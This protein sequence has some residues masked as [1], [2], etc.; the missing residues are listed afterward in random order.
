M[1][2]S[3][4]RGIN[5]SP[6]GNQ[7]NLKTSMITALVLLG[8]V[9]ASAYSFAQTQAYPN[10]QIRIVVPLPPGGNVDLIARTIGQKLTESMQQQVRTGRTL[11]IVGTILLAL[12]T[13][14]LILIFGAIK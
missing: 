10:R 5:F 1:I 6:K 9:L 14:A 11:G 3:T 4:H 7:M 12:G 2:T 8:A 13:L